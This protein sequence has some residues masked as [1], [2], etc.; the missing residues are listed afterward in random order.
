MIRIDFSP[1]EVE[2]VQPPKQVMIRN[3]ATGAGPHSM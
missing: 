3:A 2:P 1:P